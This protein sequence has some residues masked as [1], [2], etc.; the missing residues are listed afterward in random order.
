[1]TFH[2]SDEATIVNDLD[3][4]IESNSEAARVKLNKS[5]RW[6]LHRINGQWRIVM[7]EVNRAPRPSTGPTAESLAAKGRP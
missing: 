4:V 6:T 5:D 1:M 7:L 2:G 3:A